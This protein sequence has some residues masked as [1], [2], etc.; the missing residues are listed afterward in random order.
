MY[1]VSKPLADTQFPG[2]DK[3][4]SKA[5]SKAKSK[6]SLNT[7]GTTYSKKNAKARGFTELSP[8]QLKKKRQ[9][10]KQLQEKNPNSPILKKM[11]DDYRKEISKGYYKR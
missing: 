2:D 7:S 11:K 10:M 6:S 3:K 9:A 4:K 1:R 8:V 5:K